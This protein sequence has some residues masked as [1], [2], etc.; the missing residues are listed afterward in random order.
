MRAISKRPY[1]FAL[2]CLYLLFILRVVGQILVA[3]FNVPFLPPMADWYSGLIPYPLL[4]FCQFAIIALFGK[5]CIDFAGLGGHFAVPDRKLGVALTRFGML[6]V[7]AMMIRY[8][9]LLG[10]HPHEIWVRG[11]I[12]IVFHWVLASFL[13]VLADYHHRA[14]SVVSRRNVDTMPILSTAGAIEHA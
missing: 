8:A 1:F 14:S 13:L 9:L 3:F 7:S 11:C 4:L 2:L 12:P 10:T 6:Y 5:I